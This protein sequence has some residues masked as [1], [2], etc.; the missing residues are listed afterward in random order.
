ML[1]CLPSGSTGGTGSPSRYMT[2]PLGITILSPVLFIH[3]GDIFPLFNDLL[4]LYTGYQCVDFPGPGVSDPMSE[5]PFFEFIGAPNY[6]H[7]DQKKRVV[8][9]FESFSKDHAKQYMKDVE[10]AQRKTNFN[11][12]FRCVIVNTAVFVCCNYV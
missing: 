4:V 12:N 2:Q 5:N 9:E 1:A 7:G 8:T 3:V 10:L 6:S 11:H